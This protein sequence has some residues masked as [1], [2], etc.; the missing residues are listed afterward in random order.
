[1]SLEIGGIADKLGNEYEALWG[2]MP[3][4]PCNKWRSQICLS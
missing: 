1:M 3:T 4:D 2:G